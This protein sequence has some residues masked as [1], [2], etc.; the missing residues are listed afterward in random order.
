MGTNSSYINHTN[1]IIM[2]YI[3]TIKKTTLFEI[4]EEDLK[5]QVVKVLREMGDKVRVAIEVTPENFKHVLD[6][7]YNSGY[8]NGF[9]DRVVAC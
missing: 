1:T 6:I 3:I 5:D 9:K 2:E 7:F 4:P 8:K